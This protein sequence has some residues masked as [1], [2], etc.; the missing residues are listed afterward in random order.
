MHVAAAAAAELLPHVFI[1]NAAPT[2]RTFE[3]LQ[4][5]YQMSQATH[6]NNQT[7]FKIFLSCSCWHDICSQSHSKTVDVYRLPSNV[8]APYATVESMGARRPQYSLSSALVEN[9][10]QGTPSWS[11]FFHIITASFTHTIVRQILPIANVQGHL[12]PNPPL[13][14]VSK[15]HF[16]LRSVGQYLIYA[17]SKQRIMATVAPN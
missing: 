12:S 9:Q 2:L 6:P 3:L 14:M 13:E 16:L 5:A 4:R 10:M 11:L 1:I 7:N 17:S 15:Q 8:R